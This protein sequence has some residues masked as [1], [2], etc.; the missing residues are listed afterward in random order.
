MP[1]QEGSGAREFTAEVSHVT[2]G[3]AGNQNTFRAPTTDLEKRTNAL[4]D[5]VNELESFVHALLGTSE[6]SI[7]GVQGQFNTSHTHDGNGD[8]RIDFQRVYNNGDDAAAMVLA[9]N[10]SLSITL[11]SAS[12]V[13][14]IASD[15]LTNIMEIDNDTQ[16]VTVKN[17]VVV[18]P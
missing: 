12:T 6:T 7:A 9:T 16:T 11:N 8:T 1:V 4:F 5:F 10:G 2:N 17:A 13:N 18:S 3:D 14:F 15:G